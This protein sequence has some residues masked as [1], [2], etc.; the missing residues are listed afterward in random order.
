[1][2]FWSRNVPIRVDAVGL[3]VNAATR[4]EAHTGHGE[5]GIAL[6]RVAAAFA[7]GNLRKT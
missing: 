4:T 5:K 3:A 2:S 1:M 6:V 7:P